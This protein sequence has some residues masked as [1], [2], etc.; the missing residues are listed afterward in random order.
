[1]E[2]NKSSIRALERRL[3]GFAERR[4]KLSALN[5]SLFVVLNQFEQVDKRFQ[6][7]EEVTICKKRSGKS[8]QNSHYRARKL[9]NAHSN[10]SPRT[11]TREVQ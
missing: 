7:S 10:R 3:N 1:M 11:N 6:I 5:G 2:F 4:L 9:E 8:H